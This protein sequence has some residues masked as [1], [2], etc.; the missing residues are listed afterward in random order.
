VAVD[1]RT[2]SDPAAVHAIHDEECARG[3]DANSIARQVTRREA[4]TLWGLTGLARRANVLQRYML[5]T[6]KPDG[7]AEDLARYRNVTPVSI[8]AAIARWLS[9]SRMVEVTTLPAT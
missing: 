4:G 7:L 3:I 9:P 6:G 2:G 5:Y 8:E 1:L